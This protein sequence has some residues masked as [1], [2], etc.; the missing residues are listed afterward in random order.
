MQTGTLGWDYIKAYDW[1][2]SSNDVTDIPLKV[3]EQYF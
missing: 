1:S 3:S 2:D